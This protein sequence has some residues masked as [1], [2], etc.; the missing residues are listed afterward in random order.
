[1]QTSVRINVFQNLQGRGVRRICCC[2]RLHLLI[3]GNVSE[4]DKQRKIREGA[5]IQT[6]KKA[7]EKEEAKALRIQ[8]EKKYTL[9][10]MMKV[11]DRSY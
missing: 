11:R 2:V 6:Q 8:Q 10:A 1:M 9:E 3:Y 7:L 4:K 5:V